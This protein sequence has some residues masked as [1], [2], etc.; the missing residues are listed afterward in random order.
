MVH[1]SGQTKTPYLYG[2][3]DKN[4]LKLKQTDKS[5]KVRRGEFEKCSKK[6]IYFSKPSQDPF[7]STS[8]L[9]V[10]P[11]LRQDLREI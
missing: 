8:K 2:V 5:H 7:L 11:V 9:M 6:Q 4:K 3:P 10:A 1:K